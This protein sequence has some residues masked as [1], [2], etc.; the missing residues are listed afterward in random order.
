MRRVWLL[1]ALLGLGCQ[2]RAGELVDAT[3]RTVTIPDAPRRVLPAGPP[4]AV[5]LQALAPDLMIGWPHSLTPAQRA[6]LPGSVAGLPEVPM[7]T[8][9]SDQTA[10]IPALHPD[11]VLDYGTVSARY[12]QLDEGIQARTGVPTVLLDGALPRAPAVIRALGVALH[13]Q[14]RAEVL[15]RA[16][17]A[18]LRGVPGG[19]SRTVVLARGADGLDLAA[20]GSPAV[21]VFDVLGWRVL[22][23]GVGHAADAASV[24]RLDPDVVVFADAA[25]RA[26]VAHAPAWQA[27]RAVR[28]GRAF[29]APALPFGWFGSPPSINRLTGV[30]A[31]EGAPAAAAWLTAMEGRPPGADEA[32][33]EP[34]RP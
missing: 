5:L 13:R 24:G 20:P 11:L 1:V 26:V 29:V 15:A 22:S 34:V 2:A 8:G 9:H 19:P 14:A 3:G 10:F 31:F 23:T 18:V 4:A 33:F 12:V 7:L 21:A 28:E 32:R 30:A 16:A 6:V 25:M 27:L 17:E